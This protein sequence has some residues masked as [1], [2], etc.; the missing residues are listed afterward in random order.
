MADCYD[1]LYLAKA[2][3]WYVEEFN[4]GFLSNHYNFDT[5]G[6]HRAY[7]DAQNTGKLFVSLINEISNCSKESY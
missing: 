4:L 5:E 2:L 7:K 1:T 3:I 6:A